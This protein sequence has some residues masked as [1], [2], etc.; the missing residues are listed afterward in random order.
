[1]PIA[2]YVSRPKK[3]IITNNLEFVPHIYPLHTMV[4]QGFF[5]DS[6]LK[7]TFCLANTTFLKGK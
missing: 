5:Q 1:M 3:K 2:S 7:K 6:R 4:L